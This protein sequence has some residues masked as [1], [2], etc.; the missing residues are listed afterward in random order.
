M[1][2][3]AGNI[4]YAVGV[5]PTLVAGQETHCVYA[6]QANGIDRADTAGCNGCGWRTD[7]MHT[8]NTIDRHAVAFK[9]TS[10]GAY[11]EGV[12]TLRASG[13]D[14]GGGNGEHHR[15]QRSG[16]G[17]DELHSQRNSGNAQSAGSRTPAG[18]LHTFAPTANFCG[19]YGETGVAATLETRYHYGSGGDAALIVDGK[20]VFENQPT[21]SRIKGPL[22][23]CQ[24]LSARMGT[25]GNVP[26]VLER[27]DE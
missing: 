20:Y 12:G 6:L 19:G 2:A 16:W 13:G 24:T 4:G 15:P 25:G 10:F 8:L 14:N 23:V 21:D 3:K 9:Q 27:T 26:I 7:Q 18:N 5:T 1:G 11:D 17:F 22:S